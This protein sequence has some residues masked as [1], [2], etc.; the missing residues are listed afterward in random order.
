VFGAVISYLMQCVSFIL[1][2]RNLPNIKRPF[3][4]PVGV[5]GA[6]VAGIIALLSLGAILYNDEYRP[7]VYGVAAVYLVALAYFAIAGRHRLVYSP[8]EEFAME[9]REGKHDAFAHTR[10]EGWEHPDPP[11]SERMGKPE[12]PDK[13]PPA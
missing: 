1:L 6:A 2:R 3:V 7:G 5:P 4:S 11:E 8:E 9:M 13:P 10:L 12:P